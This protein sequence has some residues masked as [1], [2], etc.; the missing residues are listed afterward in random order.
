MSG[1]SGKRTPIDWEAARTRLERLGEWSERAGRPELDRID[2][3]YRRRAELAA[4]P[5][6]PEGELPGA[7]EIV[8]FRLGNERFGVPLSR[9]LG[10]LPNPPCAPVPGAPPEIAGVI[11]VRGEI[12]PVCDLSRILGLP[13]EEREGSRSV[14]LL[15]S[16]AREFG[17]FVDSVEDI[18]MLSSEDRGAPPEAL[19]RHASWITQDLIPVLNTDSL[20]EEEAQ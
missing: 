9:V 6:R 5:L 8:V 13:A 17:A 2:A 12:R 11:Q 10:I 4:R 20:L 18:A 1:P 14:L 16:A 3:T 15:S 7:G 19:S